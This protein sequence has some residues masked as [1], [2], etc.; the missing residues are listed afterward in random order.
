VKA[1]TGSAT[2]YIPVTGWVAVIGGTILLGSAAMIM[3][4]RWVLR[5]RPAEALGIRE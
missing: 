5:M 2:P 1:I 4:V 3:P